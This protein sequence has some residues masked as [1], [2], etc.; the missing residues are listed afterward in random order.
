MGNALAPQ[1]EEFSR[2]PCVRGA[3]VACESGAAMGRL[4]EGD[5]G[6]AQMGGRGGPQQLAG[7]LAWQPWERTIETF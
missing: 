3:K 5:E 2:N 4:R 6:G 7:Q 1:A